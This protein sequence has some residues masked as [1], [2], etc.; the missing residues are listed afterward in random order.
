MA[1][2]KLGTTL[3]LRERSLLAGGS[4]DLTGYL[5]EP[6]T[7]GPWPGVVVIHEALGADEVMERHAER[8]AEAGYLT[9]MPDLF[10]DGGL[11]R[12]LVSTMRSIVSGRGKA[13]GDIE[14][15]RRELVDNPNCTGKVGLIGFC[16][17]GAFALLTASNGKY[18]AVSTNYGRP[19]RRLDTLLEGSCPVVGSYGA[20]DF[21]M[22][23]A[24]KELEEALTLHDVPHDVKEYPDAGHCFLNDSENAPT[25]SLPITRIA[26]VR[27]HP[28]SAV[29]AWERIDSFFHEHLRDRKDRSGDRA[30]LVQ[31]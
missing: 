23:G 28:E 16:M 9:L 19:P 18:D 1:N 12:C 29:D 2:H 25:W 21:S 15:A 20:K 11:R 31:K 4:T 14:A 17:G 3:D 13:F 22:R 8:M 24:A 6:T 10:S 26:N 30:H 27:P 7:P 5:V